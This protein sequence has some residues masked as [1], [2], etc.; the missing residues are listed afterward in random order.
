MLLLCAV[1]TK[2]D[3]VCSDGLQDHSDLKKN[4]NKTGH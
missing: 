4:Q 1:G 3:P 2:S